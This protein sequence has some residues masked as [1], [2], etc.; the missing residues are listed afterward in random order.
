MYRPLVALLAL[1]TS[2]FAETHDIDVGEDGQ[3]TFDPRELTAEA[4]DR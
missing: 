3:L 4:G 2:V 1:T